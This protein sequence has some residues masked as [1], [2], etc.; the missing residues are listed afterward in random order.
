[1]SRS[2][3]GF[4]ALVLIFS[5]LLPKSYTT[6]I[7]V[8]AGN[9]S[10][11]PSAEGDNPNRQLPFLNA[12]LAASG[13]QSAETYVELF[14]ETPVVQQVRRTWASSMGQ[15]DLLKHVQI[16]PVTNTSIIDLSVTWSNPNTVG[17]DR[18]RVRFG[19]GRSPAPTGLQQAQQAI[20]FLSKQL[21]AAQ[22]T[23]HDAQ[24]QTRELR[25][26]PPHRGY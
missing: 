26:D 16:K 15:R 11:V 6:D 17:A 12:I 8:I 25:G 1:M 9:S 2:F 13:V 24:M 4:I 18:Q 20:D 7:K 22:K 14:Q 10:A 5:L 21:P 19:R 3:F 23:M